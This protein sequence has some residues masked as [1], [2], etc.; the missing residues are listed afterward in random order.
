MNLRA[1]HDPN[2]Q[3]TKQESTKENNKQATKEKQEKIKDKIP[4]EQKTRTVQLNKEDNN[5]E[6]PLPAEEEIEGRY[7]DEL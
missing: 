1:S 4:Q 5:D 6:M 3:P 7:K 2:V